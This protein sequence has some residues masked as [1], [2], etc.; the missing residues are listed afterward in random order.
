MTHIP[1]LPAAALLALIPLAP[2]CSGSHLTGDAPTDSGIESDAPIDAGIEWTELEWPEVGPYDADVPPP[3]VEPE[4]GDGTLD[5]GEECDDGNRLDGDGCD[6]LCRIGDGDPPPSVDPSVRDYVPDGDPVLLDGDPDLLYG[7]ELAG[8]RLPITWTG[9]EY[10]AA[11]IVF[12]TYPPPEDCQRGI[13]FVRFDRMGDV[14][15]S[16]WTYALPDMSYGLDLVWTGSEHGLFFDVS[17][18]GIH[19]L[20]L[21]AEGKPIAGPIVIEPDP[22]AHSP[23]ADLAE[24]GYV[25]VWSSGWIQARARLARLDGGVDGLPGPVALRDGTWGVMDV[26]S[27]DG[28]YAI[29]IE[30]FNPV[31]HTDSFRVLWASEDLSLV[32]SSGTLSN[33]LGGDVVWVDGAYSTAW[34]HMEDYGIPDW[35]DTCVARI[36]AAGDLERAPV[37]TETGFHASGSH[38]YP[39]LT[40]LAAG[41]GGL[42]IVLPSGDD[43]PDAFP[44]F[45]RTDHIGAPVSGP[46]EIDPGAVTGHVLHVAIAWGPGEYGLLFLFQPRLW[47]QR[48]VAD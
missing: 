22:D 41:D 16:G 26:A 34:T 21:D 12:E 9:S 32:R 29:S 48:L 25:V 15:D 30:Q 47:M 35:Y 3:P 5:D 17:G 36:T 44:I 11:Y 33:G 37:C 40:R 38:G 24:A 28:G 31:T 14:V 27:G 7:G 39:G 8:Q 42:G 2:A 13:R 23:S 1:R 19:L 46:V 6:W 20:R 10:A 45:L 4:C 43:L 18:R